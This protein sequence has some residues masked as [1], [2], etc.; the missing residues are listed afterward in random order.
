M[1]AGLL[2]RLLGGDRVW[3]P[4]CVIVLNADAT[5][6]SPGP[7]SIMSGGIKHYA[8]RYTSGRVEADTCCLLR[9]KH[10]LLIVQQHEYK[11]GTGQIR[12]RHTLVV[13]DLD[14]VVGL[15]FSDLHA[16]ESLGIPTPLIPEDHEYRPGMLVG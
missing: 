12:R 11:E 13:T 16:L 7:D 15:E 1:D 10:A 4:A 9:D 14:H 6:K 2:E 3:S 5:V 8:P